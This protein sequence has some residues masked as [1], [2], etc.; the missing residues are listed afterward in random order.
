M[1]TPRASTCVKRLTCAVSVT[2]YVREVSLG[3][4][5]VVGRRL[6]GERREPVG[7]LLPRRVLRGRGRWRRYKVLPALRLLLY[8]VSK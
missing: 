6:R 5:C 4:E 8:N 2:E 7:G 3:H 1:A